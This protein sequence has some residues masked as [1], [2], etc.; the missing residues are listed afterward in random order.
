M[1]DINFDDYIDRLAEKD[2]EAF[3]IVYEATK[4]GVFSI[5]ISLVKNKTVTED[6]MQDTY[7]R[8]LEKIHTYKKGRNFNAWLV[9][10]AKNL[11]LD[12]L[13]KENR[14]TS[15][16]PQESSYM[17]EGSY[18]KPDQTYEVEEMIGDLD[19]DERQVVM[20]RVVNDYKFKA[21]AS[22]VD[23]PLGTTLWLYNKAIKK[24]KK[25]YGKGKE[26]PK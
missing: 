5:I 21:I 18:H 26:E 13:R 10:I 16:D 20:L 2:E 11:T 23:K 4:K 17:F 6:L 19:P 3:R 15:V 9:Q 22:I 24:L 7:I 12:Y 14:H 25:R 1:A 8:M